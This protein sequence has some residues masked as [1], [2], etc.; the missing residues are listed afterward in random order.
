MVKH[1][2]TEIE[3]VADQVRRSFEGQ[4][5]HG[6]SVR[7]AIAGVSA[8]QAA[9]KPVATAHSIWELLLHMGFWTEAVR[10]RL[11]GEV[12]SSEPPTKENF[13]T[14][15][16]ASEAAWKQAQERVE[17]LHAGLMQELQRC[18]DSR[19]GE[20]V[21]GTRRRFYFELLGLAQHNAYHAA[22][23]MLLKKM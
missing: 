1:A 22:Q 21:P 17:A 6:P 19:L 16:D 3:R 13:P 4:A 15:A 10:R 11:V 12:V 2:V 9:R 8:A 14:V 23:M 20:N 5:W 18:T 7:E